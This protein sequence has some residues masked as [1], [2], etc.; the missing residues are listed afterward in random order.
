MSAV[1]HIKGVKA[2]VKALEQQAKVRQQRLHAGLKK[3]GLFL[4][5]ES[6]KIVPVQ[7]GILRASAFTRAE[8]EGKD[9][10]VRVGYTA[11]YAIFVHE[12][13][14]SHHEVGQAKFLEAPA[15][16]KTSQLIAIIRAEASK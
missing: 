16:E 6:Q 7:Y 11:Q 1:L 2:A 8:G 3:G 15:R 14:D 10:F 4:Q 13:L 9:F 12:N 5:R